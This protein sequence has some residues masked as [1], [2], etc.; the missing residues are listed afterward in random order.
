MHLIDGLDRHVA[1]GAFD[2]V[3]VL[4]CSTPERIGY[5]AEEIAGL[6]VAVLDHHA[7][8]EE[9][10]EVR[11]VDPGAPS[12]TYLIQLFI[13]S[14]NDSP[15]PEEAELLLFGL[16]TDTGFFRHLTAG[17]EEVFAAV[18]RLTSLGASPRDIHHTMF[19][20]RSYESRRLLGE[21]LSRTERHCGGRLLLSVER[22]EDQQRF[23]REN[24]DSDTLYQQLQGVR[25]ADVVVL[26]REEEPG[27]CSV[28]LRSRDGLD[29]GSLARRLGGGG[30]R[31]AAG[32]TADGKAEDIRTTVLERLAGLLS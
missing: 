31:N 20:G 32:F 15:T 30:H 6:P 2:A 9:F 26:I 22:L 16:C 18:G 13:E 21:L 7:S 17:S 1:P 11:I 28:G 19:G 10:G 4:D 3:V 23:G 5:L 14:C 27:K 25:G 12:V 29:V 24:R 8:G